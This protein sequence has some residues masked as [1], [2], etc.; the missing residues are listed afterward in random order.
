MQGIIYEEVSFLPFF[1]ITCALGGWA[2]WMTGR[3]CALTW[4]GMAQAFVYMLPLGL[5]VRFV[6]FVIAGSTLL[7]VH[8]YAVD[9]AVL[10]IFCALGFQYTR[11]SQMVRQYSWLF[12]KSSPF[13]WQRINT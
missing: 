7:S 6:H 12:K 5:A 13:S 1:I 8:Y 10:L 9:T 2:A 11:T 3:G 4:R